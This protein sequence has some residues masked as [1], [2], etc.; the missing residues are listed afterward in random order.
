MSA[1]TNTYDDALVGKPDRK[2]SGAESAVLETASHMRIL[3]AGGAGYIGA[4]I[5]LHIF[6]S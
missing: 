4:H 3:V 6:E 2:D 1:A 5:V